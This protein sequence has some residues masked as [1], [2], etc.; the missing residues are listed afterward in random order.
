MYEK[1]PRNSVVEKP[2]KR[3]ILDAEFSVWVT[4]RVA[5]YLRVSTDEQSTERQERELTEAAACMGH[6]VVE[7]YADNGVSG[8]KGRN[9]RPASGMRLAKLRGT[10]SGKP[11]GRPRVPEHTREAIQTAYQAG[12]IGMRALAKRYW[13]SLG[14][15][16]TLLNRDH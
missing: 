12:G 5:L 13:V 3:A 14:T 6:E 1:T 11:I 2:A 4:V 7:V 15:V 9:R 10:K 8:A 16:Q